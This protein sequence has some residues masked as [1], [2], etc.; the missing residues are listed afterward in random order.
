MPVSAIIGAQFGDEAKGKVTDYLCARADISVRYQGGPNA[1]H[2]VQP[3]EQMVVLHQLS[4]GILRSGCV[5]VSGPGMVISPPS[6]LDEL[7][8][9][10]RQGELR[11]EL[12]VSERAHVVLPLHRAQDGW[13]EKVRGVHATGTTLRGIGPAYMD[14]V[15][16]WGI[17]MADLSRPEIIKQ[18]LELLYAAKKHLRD[19]VPDLPSID[20][21][22]EELRQQGLALKPYLA[23]TEPYL[24]G[25]ARSGKRIILEGAQSALLDVDFGT[26]PFVTSSHPTAAGALVGS[27]LPPQELDDVVGVAKAYSTRVGSGPFPTELEGAAADRL[28]EMGGERGATTGRPRRCGWMDLVLLRYAARLNGFTSL[29]ITKVDVLGGEPEVPVCV[30]YELPN[31]ER[32]DEYP[33]VL[34]EDLEAVSPVWRTFPG[35]GEFTPKLRARLA[36]QGWRALPTELKR[37]LAFIGGETGAPVTVV[38]YGPRRDETVEVPPNAFETAAGIS[39]WHPN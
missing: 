13:E 25:A 28:R 38:S 35:W 30:G 9:L 14:R 24:W 10:R 34:A 2:S 32:S 27:G 37:Y 4:A 22:T 18:K 33:P 12:R 7:E 36:E 8:G 23:N 39:E 3:G 20:T 1:G 31:G 19:E 15:G 21:L 29:A 5:A 16:R 6:L 11:G 26:Y 17:R